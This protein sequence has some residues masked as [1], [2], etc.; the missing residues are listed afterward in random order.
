MTAAVSGP[1]GSVRPAPSPD[2]KMIAFVRREATKSKLYVK[3]I[4]SG[5]ERK[6]YDALDQDVQETWAVTGVYP[7]MDWTPDSRSIVF[8]AGG[9]LR[10][11]DADERRGARN[12][13]SA[14]TTR[15]A[16]PTRPI[17]R[18]RSRPIVSRPRCR[19]S[20]KCRPTGARWC[21]K[22]L[23]NCG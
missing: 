20:P 19:A 9:K 13:R 14:S 17:R 10:R 1:G 12:S 16:S 11:V 7:N 6:V 21:S 8:W 2:G 4:A 23:A 3:D 18:S 15:A 5:I 22:A